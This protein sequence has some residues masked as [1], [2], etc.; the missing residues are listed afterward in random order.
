M[1]VDFL[2]HSKYEKEFNVTYILNFQLLL[3]TLCFHIPNL[4]IVTVCEQI[5]TGINP[6]KLS[7]LLIAI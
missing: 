1:A 6:I 5:L 3:L 2:F 4:G 7:R